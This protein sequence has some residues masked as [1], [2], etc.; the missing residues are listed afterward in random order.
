MKS[1]RKGLSRS[2]RRST[3]KIGDALIEG[4]ALAVRHA[5]GE[6][7]LPGRRLKQRASFRREAAQSL[8]HYRETGLHVTQAEVESLGR[9]AG[10]AAA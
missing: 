6:V 3:V 7:D 2:S 4:L 9:F 10:D 5:R 8:R 1:K